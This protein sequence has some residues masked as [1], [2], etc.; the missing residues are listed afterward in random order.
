MLRLY[1]NSTDRETKMAIWL[2]AANMEDEHAVNQTKYEKQHKT[3]N[4]LNSQRT[5]SF[6]RSRGENTR[7]RRTPNLELE[8][9]KW[10]IDIKKIWIPKSK[11]K[12]FNRYRVEIGGKVSSPHLDTRTSTSLA[13]GKKEKTNGLGFST[14]ESIFPKAKLDRSGYLGPHKTVNKNKCNWT[15]PDLTEKMEAIRRADS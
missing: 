9:E 6:N 12:W 3:S 11:P 15:N 2:E 1:S 8:C 13:T 14:C 4:K 7:N 10:V 5:K